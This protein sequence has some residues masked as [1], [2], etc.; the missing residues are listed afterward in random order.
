MRL[1]DHSLELLLQA[2]V[3]LYDGNDNL[4]VSGTKEELPAEYRSDLDNW[5]KKLEQ[6]GIII[7]GIVSVTG[8]W[9]VTLT[10][11][12]LMYFEE[13]AKREKQEKQQKNK[14]RLHD[15]LMLFVSELCSLFTLNLQN[16]GTY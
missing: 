13:K 9:K 3:N 14:D 1:I 10:R 8:K 4:T 5:L 7:T 11:D 16:P 12:G 2:I 6:N 15:F